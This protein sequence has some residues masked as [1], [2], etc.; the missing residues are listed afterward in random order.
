MVDYVFSIEFTVCQNYFTASINIMC[1]LSI[2]PYLLNLTLY[3]FVGPK[4]LVRACRP[5]PHAA[6]YLATCCLPI[7]PIL[8]QREYAKILDKSCTVWTLFRQKKRALFFSHN[9]YI[10]LEYKVCLHRTF[11]EMYPESSSKS[12][13]TIARPSS[14]SSRQTLVR[15]K[16]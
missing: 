9:I 3:I 2:H 5:A 12:K 11:L 13:K 16:E 6:K 7:H 15:Q 10:Y 4:C 14:D 8:C 1:E